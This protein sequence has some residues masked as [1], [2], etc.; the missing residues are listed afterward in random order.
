[1]VAVK[2][3]IT[4]VEGRASAKQNIRDAA[5]ALDRA[6]AEYE[7]LI[8]LLDPL[9]PAAAERLAAAKAKRDA[10]QE[11]FDQLGGLSASVTITAATDWDR[12]TFDERRD[13][14]RAVV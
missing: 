7:K 14:I 6:Q 11:H 9:E 8:E 4:D 1:V 3:A 2:E 10:A 13:L 12:L 5:A